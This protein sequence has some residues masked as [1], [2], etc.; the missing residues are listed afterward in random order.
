MHVCNRP[1]R[2][3]CLFMSKTMP[4]KIVQTLIPT[5]AAKKNKKGYPARLH[6]GRERREEGEGG[7]RE[8]EGGGRGREGKK[9]E[10]Q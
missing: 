2:T 6:K 4:A 9:E 5:R 1:S 10:Q 8:R 7:R 3:F